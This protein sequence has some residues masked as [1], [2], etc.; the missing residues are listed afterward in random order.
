MSFTA[1]DEATLSFSS[2]APSSHCVHTV[3]TLWRIRSSTRPRLAL[4]HVPFPSACCCCLVTESCL[5]L[6]NPMDFHLPGSSVHGI[7]QANT[8]V[9]CHF[10][11]Q[12]ICPTRGSNPSLLHWQ[13]NSLPSEP[14]GEPLSWVPP[15]IKPPPPLCRLGL[16]ADRHKSILEIPTSRQRFPGVLTPVSHSVC[17]QCS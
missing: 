1:G 9:G 10:L 4:H 13:V 16:S 2:P 3:S 6:C 7:F 14:P 8:G 17:Y 11:L 12:G 5:T 15:T